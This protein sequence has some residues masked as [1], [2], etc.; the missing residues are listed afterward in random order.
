MGQNR[1]YSGCVGHI[2]DVLGLGVREQIIFSVF[3]FCCLLTFYEVMIHYFFFLGKENKTIY[4]TLL[5]DNMGYPNYQF[6]STAGYAGSA[7]QGK[8]P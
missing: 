3:N 2:N 5:I 8:L 1:F 7:F 6:I 4:P